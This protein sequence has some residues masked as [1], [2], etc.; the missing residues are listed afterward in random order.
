M[1]KNVLTLTAMV[2]FTIAV[3]GQAGINNASPKSPLDITGATVVTVVCGVLVPHFM[4]SELTGK[5]NAQIGTLVF[6]TAGTGAAG[7]T[8]SAIV[9]HGIKE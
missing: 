2:L 1:K 6:V 4:V 3:P 7:S 9:I 5:D 8:T